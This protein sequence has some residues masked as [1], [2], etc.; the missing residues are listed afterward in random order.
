MSSRTTE[1]PAAMMAG[2]SHGQSPKTEMR[3]VDAVPLAPMPDGGAGDAGGGVAGG[4]AGGGG[5]GP[6][7]VSTFTTGGEIASSETPSAAEA[8]AAPTEERAARDVQWVDESSCVSASMVAVMATDAAV[9]MIVT[10]EGDT[11]MIVARAMPKAVELKSSM[12]PAAV[13]V[14]TTSYAMDAPG[15]S[16]GVGGGGD[17]G[18]GEGGKGGGEGGGGLGGGSEGLG[19]MFGGREGNGG[20]GDAG[21]KEP[22]PDSPEPMS[23]PWTSEADPNSEPDPMSLS[24]RRRAGVRM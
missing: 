23:P 7:R 11:P 15:V 22:E 3:H 16:G 17:G 24:M 14:C 8:A 4:G 20:G 10:A 6:R 12:E 21:R 13:N 18:G 19:G 5:D 9:A 1:L 2:H